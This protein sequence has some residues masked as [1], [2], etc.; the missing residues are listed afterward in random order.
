MR[1]M[2][3][4]QAMRLAGAGIAVGLLAAAVMGRFL[5]SLLYGVTPLDPLTFLGGLLIF[6][7]VAALAALIPALRAARVPPAVA[8]QST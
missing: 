1:R 3:L 8:L 4:L 6:L 7:G 5:T 2:I